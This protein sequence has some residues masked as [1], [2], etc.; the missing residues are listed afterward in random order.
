[1]TWFRRMERNG[2]KIHWI[3]G[4]LPIQQKVETAL[5]ILEGASWAFPCGS[6][7]PLNLSPIKNREKDTAAIPNATKPMR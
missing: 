6:G 4:N 3:D 5:E 1:M 7:F 2:F